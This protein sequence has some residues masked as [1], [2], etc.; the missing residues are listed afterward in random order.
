MK[1]LKNISTVNLIAYFDSIVANK[2]SLEDQ[3]ILNGI[4]ENI[5][6][7]YLHYLEHFDTEEL[8]NIANSDYPPNHSALLSCYK[9]AGTTLKELKRE[10]RDSQ[11]EDIKGTCQYCDIGKPKTFDHY[12]PIG[13]YPEYSVLAINLIP[14]CKDCNEKKKAYWKGENGVRGI[15]NF[16]IDNIPNT[17]FLFGD[18]KFIE[19][20]PCVKFEIENVNNEINIGLYSTIENHFNRLKLIPEYNSLAVEELSEMHRTFT[21]YMEYSTLIGM[22]EK[23]MDDANQL[24]QQFGV[25]YWRAVIR[26]ALSNSI[27]YLTYITDKINNK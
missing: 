2:S 3:T 9:S 14:C 19:D 26:V 18:V 13:D 6:E 21:T 4:R 5:N 16:Y 23:L 22:V 20:I 8:I 10:I 15:L 25:N 11:D 27:E 12:V 7:K 17:Q 24:Q 1:Q